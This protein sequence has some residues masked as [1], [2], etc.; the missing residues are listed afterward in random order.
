MELKHTHCSTTDT[1]R[2]YKR[3]FTT[4]ASEPRLRILNLLR[5]GP[6][7]VNAIIEALD[8]DQPSVSHDLA[9]LRECGFV[10]TKRDGRMIEYSLNE[11]TIRPILN[12]IDEHMD[13]YCLRIVR[14]LGT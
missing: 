11:E 7:H 4:L 10:K 3:F 6:H 9:R 13:A 12:L 5:K 2:A 14:T 8:R 1:Y